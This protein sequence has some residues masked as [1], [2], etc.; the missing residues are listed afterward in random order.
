MLGDGDNAVRVT[1][2]PARYSPALYVP[3]G[4]TT[5]VRGG[6]TFCSWPPGTTYAGWP[7]PAGD[8]RVDLRRRR[9][10]VAGESK[11][12]LRERPLRPDDLRVLGVSAH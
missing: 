9:P 11:L 8:H 1:W 4:A 7:E 2:D 3:T 5:T 12:C 10:A 6:R